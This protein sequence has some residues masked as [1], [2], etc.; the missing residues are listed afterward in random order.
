[1]KLSYILFNKMTVCNAFFFI[2]NQK[3]L[4]NSALIDLGLSDFLK[5]KITYN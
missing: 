3:K 5:D 1:M 2:S 4:Q